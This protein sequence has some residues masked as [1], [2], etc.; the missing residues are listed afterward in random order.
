MQ[1]MFRAL[2]EYETFTYHELGLD[3]GKDLGQE[4]QLLP[5][6]EKQPRLFVSLRID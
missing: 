1:G 4:L 3:H 6:D 2:T 5:E